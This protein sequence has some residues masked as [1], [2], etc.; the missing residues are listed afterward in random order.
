MEIKYVALRL[1]IVPRFIN[2][3]FP[4]I[5]IYYQKKIINVEDIMD[6]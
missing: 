5:N 4:V 2:Y 6:C 3:K 1:A